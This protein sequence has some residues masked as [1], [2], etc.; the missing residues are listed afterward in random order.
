MKHMN[1]FIVWLGSFAAM[2]AGAALLGLALGLLWSAF[3]FGWRM[4]T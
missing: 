4:L 1:E 2:L 3:M